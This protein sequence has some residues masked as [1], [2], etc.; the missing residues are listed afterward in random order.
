MS[1]PI[2]SRVVSSL[3]SSLTHETWIFTLIF[4]SHSTFCYVTCSQ[5]IA[6]ANQER[7]DT[8]VAWEKLEEELL[9]EQQQREH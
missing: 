1:G 4:Q 3:S 8:P 9:L 6:I 2:Y 7:W 5:M